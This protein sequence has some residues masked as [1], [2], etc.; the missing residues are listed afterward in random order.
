M[1]YAVKMVLDTSI[2]KEDYS[3][4]ILLTEDEIVKLNLEGFEES[5][6]QTNTI[7]LDFFSSCPYISVY[8]SFEKIIKETSNPILIRII[9]FSMDDTEFNIRQQLNLLNRFNFS[10]MRNVRDKLLNK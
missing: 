5:D 6:N 3:E 2:S 4:F 7:A 9:A 1:K 8:K 10:N